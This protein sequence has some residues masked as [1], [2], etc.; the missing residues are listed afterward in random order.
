[1]KRNIK[2]GII[3]LAGIGFLVSWMGKTES[4]K[5]AAADKYNVIKVDGRIIFEKTK[6]DM[7]RGDIYISGTPLNFITLQS[8][9]AVV[10]SIKGRFVLSGAEKGQT[11]ILPAANNISSRAGALINMVDLRNHFSGKYLIIDKME[12]ELN[13]DAFPMNEES[14]FYLS[15]YHNDEQIRKKLE[16]NG[17]QL[18]LDKDEIFSVDGK[19]IPVEEKEMTLFYRTDGKSSKISTFTPVFP[20]SNDLKA[21]VDIILDE[22]A[23]K[24]NETKIKEVSAYLGEF[25][26]KPQKENVEAWLKIVYDIE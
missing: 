19:P 16:H 20:D 9:A 6:A 23:D 14:F 21:E 1:M 13:E 11:K 26:G 10:S 24:D 15:Y 5:L 3:G 18:I 17:N 8:R 4:M 25:Y 22:Y 7:K 12:L 2:L